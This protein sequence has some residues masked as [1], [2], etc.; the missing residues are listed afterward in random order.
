MAP[1]AT[2]I[3]LGCA[4]YH[5]NKGEVVVVVRDVGYKQASVFLITLCCCPHL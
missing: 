3:G 2:L 4:I 1:F 5:I